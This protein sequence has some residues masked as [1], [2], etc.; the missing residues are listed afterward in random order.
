MSDSM[1]IILL[2]LGFS[3]IIAP[4]DAWLLL[5]YRPEKAS[6]H[7]QTMKNV[8]A[9]SV[10]L[11]IVIMAVTAIT[12]KNLSSV[13]RYVVEYFATITIVFSVVWLWLKIIGSVKHSPR[14]KTV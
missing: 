10:P 8:Y 9:I 6:K 14:N 7:L 3:L 5:K 12:H 1:F 4:L 13:L 11:V 2:F